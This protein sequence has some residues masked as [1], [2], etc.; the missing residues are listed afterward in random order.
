ME[1]EVKMPV[2]LSVC[3]VLLTLAILTVLLEIGTVVLVLVGIMVA[4]YILSF[5]VEI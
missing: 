4:P 3:K 2:F 5:E 1:K